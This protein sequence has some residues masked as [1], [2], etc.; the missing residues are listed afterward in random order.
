MNRKEKECLIKI[1]KNETLW[2][3]VN[4]TLID[5]FILLFCIIFI[6]LFCKTEKIKNFLKCYDLSF[7][8]V[9]IETKITVCTPL[10]TAKYA[11]FFVSECSQNIT[12][13][14]LLDHR[15]RTLSHR[16]SYFLRIHANERVNRLNHVHLSSSC[17]YI[18]GYKRNSNEKREIQTSKRRIRNRYHQESI[19]HLCTYNQ[20]ER[21]ISIHIW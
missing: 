2:I 18:F 14:P 13:S 3:N 19:Y 11:I 4:V 12:W 5:C 1:N 6:K 20:L 16:T 10:S 17:F 21:S 15:Q 7:A 9:L 8:V